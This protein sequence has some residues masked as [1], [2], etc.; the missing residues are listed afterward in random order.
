MAKNPIRALRAIMTD[1]E[2]ATATEANA[3]PFDLYRRLS[4]L[5]NCSSGSVARTM[6]EWVREGNSVKKYQIERYIKQLRKF[7]RHSQA[8]EVYL[9]FTPPALSLPSNHPIALCSFQLQVLLIRPMG[10][11]R[12]IVIGNGWILWLSALAICTLMDWMKSR[13]INWSHSNYAVR[14]GLLSKAKGNYAAEEYFES[15]P[16]PAKNMFT[17]GALLNCYCCSGEPDKAL[18][19]LAKMKA[20]NITSNTLVYNNLMSMYMKLGQPEKIPPLLHEMKDNKIA[21]DTFTYNLVMQ[22]YS[23]LKGIEAVEKV[24]DEIKEEGKLSCGWTTYSNLAAIYIA[25]GDFEKADAALKQL[26]E[27]INCR[28]TPGRQAFHFLISM[29]ASTGNSAGVKRAIESLKL[30]FPGINNTSYLVM[31]QALARLDDLDGLRLC[32]KEWEAG[33]GSY[34]VR[35]ANVLFGAYLRQDMIEEAKLL[36][37]DAVMRGGSPNFRTLELFIAFY[38]KNDQF[39][40]AMQH[41]ET[42]VAKS[43]HQHGVWQPRQEKVMAFLKH[44]EGSKDVEG[45]EN[46][47]KK[48]KKVNYLDLEVYTSLLRTYVAAGRTEPLMHQRIESD[49]IE[50]NSETEELLQKVCPIYMSAVKREKNI[51][52]GV[53]KMRMKKLSL[54]EYC[55]FHR[56]PQN[57]GVLT[58]GQLNQFVFFLT[59]SLSFVFVVVFA[60]ASRISSKT[61]CLPVSLR[62]LTSVSD[63][64]PLAYVHFSEIYLVFKDSPDFLRLRLLLL[65]HERFKKKGHRYAWLQQTPQP[66]QG[67]PLLQYY[68]PSPDLLLA[69]FSFVFVFASLEI[70]LSQKELADRVLSI[71]ALVPPT[72]S[73]LHEN[74][75]ACARLTVGEVENDLAELGWQECPVRSIKTLKSTNPNDAVGAG[76]DVHRICDSSTLDPG[77]L[78]PLI[79][80]PAAAAKGKRSKSKKR[81]HRDLQNVVD[82]NPPAAATATI[83]IL[84]EVA[85]TAAA[86]FDGDVAL[87]VPP[88]GERKA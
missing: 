43:E 65:F 34:D 71:G 74:I 62:F 9:L 2:T 44:F 20:L 15:L 3:S 17:Y 1:M 53:L 80:G 5:G 19:L 21:P 59:V 49:K 51:D 4:G 6:N 31:L 78:Q 60:D 58:I 26:E 69:I 24:V 8:L 40:L 13:G 66:S 79:V 50:M 23:V 84:A 87:L 85:A 16:E 67:N 75:S 33:H 22:S 30:A 27:N 37:E 82:A 28:A 48:L 25:A 32:F 81:K 86:A 14:I 61:F 63:K 47:Y 12:E 83:D 77:S 45:A 7:K 57:H 56:N 29:Y 72:R 11:Y 46:F 41:F 35:L 70:I 54:E 18:A 55:A 36:Y 73:T 10:Q 88:E 52:L 76:D 38:L 39:D 42:A 64:K 68:F